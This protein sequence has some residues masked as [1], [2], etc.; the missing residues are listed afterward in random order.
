[1]STLN[2]LYLM[3]SGVKD[4]GKERVH[5]RVQKITIERVLRH[6]TWLNSLVIIITRI[7]ENI[8]LKK[9]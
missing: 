8:K 7:I 1:M 6:V 4:K 2:D 9:I 5:L 3:L